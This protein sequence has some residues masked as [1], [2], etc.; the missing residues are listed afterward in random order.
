MTPLTRRTGV[1]I[2]NFEYISHINLMFQLLILNKKILAGNRRFYI[3]CS[4]ENMWNQRV[5]FPSSSTN[6]FIQR[7]LRN[8]VKYLRPIF[9]PAFI[10]FRKKFLD[11]YLCSEYA[12]VFFDPF[13]TM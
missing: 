12:S 2:V 9:L 13:K 5:F 3:Y 4:A 1:F 10:Y 7:S 8:A 6:F 11:V